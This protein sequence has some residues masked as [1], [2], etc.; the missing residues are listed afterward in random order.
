MPLICAEH[1]P[2]DVSW[3]QIGVPFPEDTGWRIEATMLG[4]TLS[5]RGFL[6]LSGGRERHEGVLSQYGAPEEWSDDDT[7]LNTVF[8]VMIRVL[9]ISRSIYVSPSSPRALSQALPQAFGFPM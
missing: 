3:F 9:K 7:P 8:F 6:N 1:L 2:Y 5:A 4:S